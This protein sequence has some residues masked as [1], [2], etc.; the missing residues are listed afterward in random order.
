M[1]LA[2]G[3][4]WSEAKDAVES[5]ANQIG[6]PY[7]LFRDTSCNLRITRLSSAPWLIDWIFIGYPHEWKGEVYSLSWKDRIPKPEGET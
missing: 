7:V 4:S 2:N 1:S 3:L 5:L 6:K